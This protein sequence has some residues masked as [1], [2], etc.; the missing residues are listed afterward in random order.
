MGWLWIFRLYWSRL[1][2]VSSF[3]I[4]KINAI[5]YSTKPKIQNATVE[6][7][8]EEGQPGP[9][10]RPV[11]VVVTVQ[12]DEKVKQ[13]SFDFGKLILIVFRSFFSTRLPEHLMF[14]AKE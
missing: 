2:D 11:P 4:N 9:S 7:D 5:N 13:V 12:D 6:D 3:L 10:A 14:Q 8:E 1:F